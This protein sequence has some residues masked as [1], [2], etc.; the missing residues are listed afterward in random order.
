MRKLKKKIERD[1][2]ESA[3]KKNKKGN[4]TMLKKMKTL[5]INSKVLPRSFPETSN[6]TMRKAIF[7][8]L[9]IGVLL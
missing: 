3:R 8:A 2:K 4:E 7:L 9:P 5:I 6:M 1:L